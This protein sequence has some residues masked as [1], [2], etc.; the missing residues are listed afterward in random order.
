MK[1]IALISS[2]VAMSLSTVALSSG[3]FEDSRLSF[4]SPIT[5][6]KGNEDPITRNQA[7]QNAAKADR[8]F[9]K[10]VREHNRKVDI[11]NLVKKDFI[12]HCSNQADIKTVEGLLSDSRAK[13]KSDDLEFYQNALITRK[14]NIVVDQ[15]ILKQRMDN[16]VNRNKDLFPEGTFEKWK[17]EDI[18]Y[19]YKTS[20]I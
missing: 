18:T 14:Q 16:V 11:F 1:K 2:M 4:D 12:K 17:C 7:F 3:K 10:N 9:R 6:E 20:A 19:F 15:A 8:H 5:Q 13:G